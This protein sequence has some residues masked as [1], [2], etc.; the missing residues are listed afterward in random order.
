M[1][2]PAK[3]TRAPEDAH[4]PPVAERNGLHRVVIIRA[5]RLH[6]ELDQQTALV[7]DVEVWL[8]RLD[9]DLALLTVALERLS[10]QREEAAVG[11]RHLAVD[12]RREA[13][14]HVAHVALASPEPELDAERLRADLAVLGLGHSEDECFD[15]RSDLGHFARLEEDLQ[16]SVRVG[17]GRCSR[18]VAD[19]RGE[20]GHDALRALAG[21][22][23]GEKEGAER[24]GRR[25]EDA[26]VP[27][28]GCESWGP[29]AGDFGACYSLVSRRWPTRGVLPGASCPDAGRACSG[30][31]EAKAL[32]IPLATNGVC[33]D[34]LVPSSGSVPAPH[35]PRFPPSTQREVSDD[36][37]PPPFVP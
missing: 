12:V 4:D 18:D 27:L 3:G 36:P 15:P 14:G 1:S 7:L 20:A 37:I 17:E 24:Q 33:R 2:P 23:R 31:G 28:P 25:G 21:G 30:K 8:G 16:P 13:R 10:R 11:E 6:P 34:A 26:H 19:R 22:K 29:G 35:Q 32:P 9:A 5:V